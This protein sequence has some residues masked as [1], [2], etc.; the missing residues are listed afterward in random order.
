MNWG[1]VD[2][3]IGRE[4]T[5]KS[6]EPH[7]L[8]RKRLLDPPQKEIRKLYKRGKARGCGEGNIDE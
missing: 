2:H 6:R 4:M 7:D 1:G 8:P 3:F 5:N